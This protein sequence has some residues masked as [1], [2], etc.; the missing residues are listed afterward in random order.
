M[1]RGE[2]LD[3]P[4]EALLLLGPMVT[5]VAEEEAATTDE[6]RRSIIPTSVFPG[7]KVLSLPACNSKFTPP[8]SAVLIEVLEKWQN[9]RAQREFALKFAESEP[10]ARNL[11]SNIDPGKPHRPKYNH[12][13]NHGR[14]LW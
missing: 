13:Y 1:E 3:S 7:A 9:S 2:Y 5:M 14:T 12:Q 11:N 4:R 6:R 10:K 8:H